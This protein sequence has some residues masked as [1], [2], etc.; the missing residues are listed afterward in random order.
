M[1]VVLFIALP[2]AQNTVAKLFRLSIRML[3]KTNP[4]HFIVTGLFWDHLLHCCLLLLIC[5]F[6][7]AAALESLPNKTN[8][9]VDRFG[10]TLALNSG[11]VIIGVSFVY[12]PVF[13]YL[14]VFFGVCNVS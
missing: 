14:F 3:Q 11:D 4:I 1:F 7:F 6:F 13:V 12:L 9:S 5:I 10:L 2:L 8:F